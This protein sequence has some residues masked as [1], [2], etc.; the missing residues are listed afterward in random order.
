[1]KLLRTL[2]LAVV[3]AGWS[4]SAQAALLDFTFTFSNRDT[5]DPGG[6]VTGIVRG[7]SDDGTSAA[8]SVE[9]FSNTG[10]FGLGEYIGIGLLN[11][12][13][14]AAGAIISYN[15][16][17]RGQ[18]NSSPAVTCCSLLL[19]NT[20]FTSTAPALRNVPEGVSAEGDSPVDITFT[21]VATAVPEPASAVLFGGALAAAALLRRRRQ[22]TA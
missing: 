11:S 8:T 1:M 18:N 3:A 22:A 19:S 10:G 9:I 20:S 2:A 7:L 4:L 12:W 13:T 15:F 5:S 16:A 6:T 17:S 21:R 14:L